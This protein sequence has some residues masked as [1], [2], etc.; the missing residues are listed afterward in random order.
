LRD[1]DRELGLA[2]YEVYRLGGHEL[3]DRLSASGLLGDFFSRLLS[4]PDERPV[5]TRPEDGPPQGQAGRTTTPSA[6]RDLL[7]VHA[8]ARERTADEHMFT[9]SG[10]SGH[11]MGTFR[12][13][14][15]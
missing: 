14:L 9:V 7:A 5:M 3:A 11:R 6:V 13:Q 4:E 10:W 12:L 1:A 2:G 15:F 8:A